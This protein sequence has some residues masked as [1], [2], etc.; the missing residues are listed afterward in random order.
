MGH[1][2]DCVTTGSVVSVDSSRIRYR[3]L[4]RR[5]SVILLHGGVT[6][7]QQMMKLGRALPTRSRCTCP[8]DEV[9]A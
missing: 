3:C 2:T 1:V 6:A 4:C 7:T 9:E 5:P 8:I